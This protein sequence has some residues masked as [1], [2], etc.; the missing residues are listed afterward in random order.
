MATRESPAV[1]RRRLRLAVRRAREAKQLTQGQV[2]DSLSW[3]LSK[4]NRIESGEVTISITDLKALLELLGVVD[5]DV[6]AGL[7]D[8]ARAARRRGWWDQ[9]KYREHLS[10]AM[11][12]LL[13]FETEATVV[14]VFQPTLIPGVLQTRAYAEIVLSLWDDVLSPEDYA[15]RLDIRMRRREQLFDRDDPPSYLLI[16]DESVLLREVG[17]PRIMSDQLEAVLAVSAMP[18][19]QIRI[20]PLADA[21]GASMIGPFTFFDLGDEENAV[22]YRESALG[23]EMSH[24]ARTMD[25]CRRLFEQMWERAMPTDASLRM[26]EARVATMR[27]DLDRSNFR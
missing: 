2:A 4:V 7:S 21:A 5:S 10:T 14:R 25:R 22:L 13:Q 23:D 17:G 1:A 11:M 19:V 15:A 8:D 3:S 12:E 18:G 24:S 9:P 27:S 20:V 26:L 6:V 16:L